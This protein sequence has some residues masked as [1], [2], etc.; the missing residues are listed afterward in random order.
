[1]EDDEAAMDSKGRFLGWME[2]MSWRAHGGQEGLGL[3]D[4]EMS[5]EGPPVAT[6]SGKAANAALGRKSDRCG[7]TLGSRIFA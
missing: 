7:I 2:N 5:E 4:G 1:M 6:P 3:K